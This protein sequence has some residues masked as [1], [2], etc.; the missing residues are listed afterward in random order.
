M[1]RRRWQLT[2]QGWLVVVLSVMGTVV[3]AGAAFAGF[4]LY[5]S[6]QV[7]HELSDDIQ[8]ARVA[9]YRVQAALR[10]QETALRGY[11]ISADRDFLAPYYDGKRAEADAAAELRDRVEGRPAL[12]ADLNAIQQAAA[13]WRADYAE[14]AIASVTPGATS[15]VDPR[16][17][18]TGKDE[19]DKIRGLLTARASTSLTPGLRA[20]PS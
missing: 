13:R 4:L 10:D 6:D 19:F 8:P 7:S 16:D 18:Q 14:P 12:I 1:P 2:V 11:L 9:A 3:L 5:R 17:L 15:V 20:S